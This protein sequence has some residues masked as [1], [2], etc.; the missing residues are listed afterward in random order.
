MYKCRPSKWLLWL[1]VFAGLPFLAASWLSAGPAVADLQT[2]AAGALAAAGAPWATL[3]VDGRDAILT[4]DAPTQDALDAAVKAVADTW[5]IRRVESNLLVKQAEVPLQPVVEA[6]AQPAALAAPVITTAAVTLAA[7]DSPLPA[8]QG[9]WPEAAGVTL[10]T[11]LADRIFTLGK[12]PELT[13]DGKGA[14]TL[15]PPAGLAPGSYDLDVTVTD[16]AGQSATATAKAVLVIP[17]LPAAASAAPAAPAVETPAAAPA[18]AYDCG[19]ALA[20]IN[21]GQPVHFAFGRTAL[22][23]DNLKVIADYAALLKDE[24]C[25]TI[26]AEVAG[27]ADYVGSL[28]FNQWLSEARAQHVVDALAADGVDAARLS[29]KGYSESEPLVNE[30]TVAARVQNRRVVI[31]LVK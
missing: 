7:P 20:Q 21:G 12:D 19:A 22:G 24:R 23:P 5:G 26:K 10:V 1:P 9:T 27:H 25:A 2:R 17:A 3:N 11:K 28:A 13:S 30:K 4:G 29:I 14:F 31:S 15:T 6:P 18:P 16:A 8:L